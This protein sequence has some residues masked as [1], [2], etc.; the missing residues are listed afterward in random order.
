MLGVPQHDKSTKSVMLRV[1]FD[2]PRASSQHEMRKRRKQRSDRGKQQLVTLRLSR[3]TI[4]VVFS[5]SQMKI[6]HN[7][8]V[9][10][11][12]CVDNSFYTGVTNNLRRRMWEHNTGYVKGCYTF[13]RRPVVLMYYEHFY[14]VDNAIAWEKQLK[15]WSRKKKEALIA[16]NWEKIKGLAAVRRSKK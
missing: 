12:C 1:P 13:K 5:L 11:V 7:Y 16:G 10:I 6:S 9:Y 8:Y 14:N 15:G 4:R 3:V 2:L